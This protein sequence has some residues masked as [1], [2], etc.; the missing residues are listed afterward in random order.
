MTI[1]V[2][3]RVPLV[4]DI[5]PGNFEF[6]VR[7]I[8]DSPRPSGFLFFNNEYLEQ[9][10]PEG[11][12]SLDRSVVNDFCRHTDRFVLAGCCPRPFERLRTAAVA[13][14]PCSLKASS[15]N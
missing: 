5:Y 8:F 12:L 13:D 10:L 6:T 1:K 7:G 4:G 14:P 11:R 3:D 2:G 15:S 9:S